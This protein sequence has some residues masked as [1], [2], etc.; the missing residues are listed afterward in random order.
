VSLWQDRDDVPHCRILS[1]DK[2]EWRLITL[3]MKTLF[4]GWP[5]MVHYTHTRRRRRIDSIKLKWEYFDVGVL[6][7][8]CAA[9]SE[10]SFRHWR[11]RGVNNVRRQ[12]V[13]SQVSLL[14]AFIIYYIFWKPTIV[15]R[16]SM[17]NWT[18]IFCH[19]Y[20]DYT[21]CSV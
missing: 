11:R 8:M 16:L 15:L 3:Q 5:V 12:C 6:T 21:P 20:K 18:L 2:T 4:R 14:A 7:N 19:N 17:Q 1:P 9:K 13:T 10:R